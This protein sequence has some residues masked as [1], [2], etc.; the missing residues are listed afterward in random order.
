MTELRRRIMLLVQEMLASN[1][2]PDGAR[3]LRDDISG[4]ANVL[5]NGRLIAVVDHVLIVSA[6][7]DPDVTSLILLVQRLR[8]KGPPFDR[9][10]ASHSVLLCLGLALF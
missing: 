9:R 4:L 6:H 5:R 7:G 1:T 2:L 3:P 8:L 10:I